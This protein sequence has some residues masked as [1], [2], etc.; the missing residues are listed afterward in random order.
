MKKF[1][2][3]RIKK[4]REERNLSLR[5]VGKRIDYNF[6]SLGKIERGE[7]SAPPEVLKDLAMLF[8]VSVSYFFGEE[9]IVPKEL[10]EL[11]ADALIIA[12]E[13]RGETLT[14]EEIEKIKSFIKFIKSEGES[15]NQ[16]Y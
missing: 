12:K 6:S 4:I 13:L 7:Y 2:G 10:K 11:G 1:I 9:Q 8:G 16:K 14:Q 15:N 5:E 3:E